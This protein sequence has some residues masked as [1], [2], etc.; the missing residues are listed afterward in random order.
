MEYKLII[1]GFTSIA[2]MKAFYNWYE[3]QGE[4]DATVWF[5]IAKDEGEIDVDFM[6]VDVHKG[7]TLE[8]TD[9][10]TTLNFTIKPQ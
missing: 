1:E 4:Q 9:E 6:G 10:V 5:E 7:S 2:Q 8:T 3:G